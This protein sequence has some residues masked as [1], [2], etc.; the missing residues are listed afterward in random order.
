MGRVEQPVLAAK[1]LLL[2]PQLPLSLRFFSFL[3]H[4]YHLLV[5]PGVLLFLGVAGHPPAF[6]FSLVAL[7]LHLRELHLPAP[8]LAG[9]PLVDHLAQAGGLVVLSECRQ[10][11][12]SAR[13]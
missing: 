1:H 13:D 5:L 9:H 3:A 7:V 4:V 10:E 2:E 6:D 11:Y 12:S 8:L